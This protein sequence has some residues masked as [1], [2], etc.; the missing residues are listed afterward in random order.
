MTYLILCLAILCE[1]F[2]TT[3]LKA[4]DS[5]SRLAPTCLAVVG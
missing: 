1:V 5:F 2:A 3:A 4:S